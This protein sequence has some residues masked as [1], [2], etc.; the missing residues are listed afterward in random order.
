MRANSN[1]KKSTKDQEAWLQVYLTPA[2]MAIG[3][4]RI[5]EIHPL[6][7]CKLREVFPVLG[8]LRCFQ[9]ARKTQVA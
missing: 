5:G 8:S 4:K 3:D 9:M 6:R 1:K 2:E 7:N